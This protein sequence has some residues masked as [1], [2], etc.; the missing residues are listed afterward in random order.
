MPYLP[1]PPPPQIYTTLFFIW[2]PLRGLGPTGS[3]G[4]SWSPYVLK[5]LSPQDI[6]TLLRPQVCLLMVLSNINGSF[7]CKFKV[8]KIQKRCSHA[9]ICRALEY[10]N[11][12]HYIW[13]HRKSCWPFTFKNK[14]EKYSTIILMK[15]SKTFF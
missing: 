4:P 3:R 14:V 10:W 13:L 5:S 7:L 11:Y 2:N 15:L 9:N 8:T 1:L 12:F 6:A